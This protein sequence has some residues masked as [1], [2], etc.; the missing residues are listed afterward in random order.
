MLFYQLSTLITSDS[1]PQAEHLRFLHSKMMISIAN[2]TE[3]RV[4]ISNVFL[5]LL[6]DPVGNTPPLFKIL[7]KQGGFQGEGY[8][9]LTR[10]I[11]IM[12][13]THIPGYLEHPQIL[14]HKIN[15]FE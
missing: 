15:S 10:V 3:N 9:L 1:A 6:L 4:Q 14:E 12:D 8:F 2:S 13:D 7:E 5:Q 11:I